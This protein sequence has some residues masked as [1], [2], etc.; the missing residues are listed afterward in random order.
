MPV[1]LIE[2]HIKLH[3]T[4]YNQWN[5]ISI[6]KSPTGFTL[7]ELIIVLTIA[8][9]L[10]AIAVPSYRFFVSNQRAE[11]I[12]TQLMTALNR[13]R[14]EA[15]RRN[16]VVQLCAS[17]GAALPACSTQANAWENGWIIRCDNCN[18][19]NTLKK[20]VNETIQVFPPPVVKDS[21]PP[22]CPPLL[23]VEGCATTLSFSATGALETPI[24]CTFGAFKIT[25]LNCKRGATINIA[26][27]GRSKQ[28]AINCP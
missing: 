26:T 23:Q 20:Y 25:P 17:N 15:I 21:C 16:V 2:N 13:A 10:A 11:A 12:S 14:H 9:I 5:D 24:A 22:R 19:D 3:Y 27:S 1:V 4:F 8:G 6:M 18:W 7:V 28:T